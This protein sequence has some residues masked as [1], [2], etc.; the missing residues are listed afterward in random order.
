LVGDGY[1]L[2]A[3]DQSV[4]RSIVVYKQNEDKITQIDNNKLIG[5]G[6]PV[7]DRTHFCEYIEKNSSLYSLRHGIP[8]TT[9]A[10]AEFTRKE[11]SEALRKGPYQ[12]SLIIGGCDEKHGPELYWCDYLGSLTSCKYTSHGY[13]S[14][15]ALS[16][17]DKYYKKNMTKQEGI[18][19]IKII[20]NELQTRFLL[21]FGPVLVKISSKEGIQQFE[22]NET[23]KEKTT[24]VGGKPMEIEQKQQ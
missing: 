22:I 12:C 8:L 2:V 3:A 24:E 14:Y 21:N 20:I 11:I 1:V 23:K 6:G 17:F 15:F 7:G 18:D 16:L 5:C 4:G 19:C 10:L 13:S 9:H